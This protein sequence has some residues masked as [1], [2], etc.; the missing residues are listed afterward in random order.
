[1][2]DQTILDR[3]ESALREAEQMRLI[4]QQRVIDRDQSDDEVVRLQ[5]KLAEKTQDCESFLCT[6]HNQ[7]EKIGALQDSLKTAERVK[8]QLSTRIKNMRA[9]ING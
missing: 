6:I 2:K 1:M 3:Y 9:Q 7:E 5:R 8:N 4:A